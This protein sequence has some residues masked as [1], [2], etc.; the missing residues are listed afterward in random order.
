MGLFNFLKKDKQEVSQTNDILA[1]LLVRATE[2]TN[3]RP[4][5]Y[6]T[7][8]S[9]E[10]IVL[11]DEVKESY[12]KTVLKKDSKIKIATFEDGK[13]PIFSSTDRIFDNR[14]ITSKVPFIGI[15]G[16][17]LLETTMGGKL[18]LNPYSNVKKELSSAEVELLLSEKINDIKEQLFL[19]L[20]QYVNKGKYVGD[21][22]KT[23]I[24]R[25]LC[26]VPRTD[27][28]EN[29]KH[30]FMENI[31]TASFRC[32]NP[33][34]IKGPDG[35]SYFHLLLPELNKEFECFVIKNIISDYL[36]SDGL[37]IAIN[38]D[39]DEPDWVFSYGDIVDF[40]LNGA[41]YTKK[42]TNPFTGIVTDVMIAENRVRIGP[43]SE[44]Y[45]PQKSRK[46]I[47]E[48]LESFGLNPKICLVLWIDQGNQLTPTFNIIPEMFK[49][50][51]S[52]SFQSFLTFLQWYFPRH[53]KVVCIQENEYFEPL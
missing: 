6:K 32:G 13:I 40:Y 7:L 31:S 20:Q 43:P 28:D 11:T 47:R 21:L 1:D 18:I 10:L 33:Q 24:I 42:I 51:D 39:K 36:L 16:K 9:S 44:T 38:A 14:I 37:G 52:E 35:M 53:Y 48:F 30:L 50:T 23:K 4:L 22:S 25:E 27:R 41:F 12:G 45:L 15:K 26:D 46:V 17:D 34:I 3:L 8:L 29:W 19:N 49:R 5:F 2:D